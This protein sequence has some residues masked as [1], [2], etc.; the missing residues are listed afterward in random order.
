MDSGGHF[1]TSTTKEEAESSISS[2][3]RLAERHNAVPDL[4]PAQEDNA[5]SKE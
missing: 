3:W 4:V 2:E 5:S 1:L